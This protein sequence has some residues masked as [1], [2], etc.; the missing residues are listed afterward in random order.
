MPRE[1]WVHLHENTNH[2]Y[3]FKTNK[4]I[5]HVLWVL[6]ITHY[7]ALCKKCLECLAH[8]YM[9]IITKDFIYEHY[10]SSYLPSAEEDW[11]RPMTICGLVGRWSHKRI[12]YAIP[13]GVSICIPWSQEK[14]TIIINYVINNK[15]WQSTCQVC[16]IVI[17]VY[18]THL[19]TLY[20]VEFASSISC[21]SGKAVTQ[22][23]FTRPSLVTETVSAWSLNSFLVLQCASGSKGASS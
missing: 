5:K 7:H 9:L 21:T 8:C 18:E 19:L 2:C 16:D 10:L 23:R 12:S 11:F 22:S 17:F 4:T 1:G 20:E 15:N 13:E 6:S 14:I 3:Y